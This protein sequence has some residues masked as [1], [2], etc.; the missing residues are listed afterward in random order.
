MTHSSHVHIFAAEGDD[1]QK[2]SD[3]DEAD[4][5]VADRHR[6]QQPAGGDADL[7]EMLWGFTITRQAFQAW[8]AM[9]PV[10]KHLVNARLQI[11]GA[12]LWQRSGLTKLIR[13]SDRGTD[14][15]ELWRMRL[16]KGGRILFEVGALYSTSPR[17]WFF[18]V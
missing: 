15:L 2:Y 9:M 12:G 14:N 18:V 10:D 17:V 4:D 5:E 8:A 3:D 1:F 16:D 6:E 11:I 7:P 13:L